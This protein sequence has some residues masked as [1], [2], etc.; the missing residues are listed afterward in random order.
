MT[1]SEKPDL[2]EDAAAQHAALSI[3]QKLDGLP[4]ALAQ[5]AGFMRRHELYVTKFWD[6]YD[7]EKALYDLH[8]FRTGTTHRG[9]Q[10]SL[11]TVWAL[12]DLEPSALSLL[13]VISML[14]P[15]CMQEAILDGE[16]PA[17]E[18]I[19]EYPCLLKEC[20]A[21]LAHLLRSSPIQRDAP[22]RE[23]RI[24][25]L[26]QDVTIVRTKGV[27]GELKSY[28]DLSTILIDV[29]W[30]FLPDDGFILA[31]RV[32]GWNMCAKLCRH[33]DQLTHIHCSLNQP[34]NSAN[35]LAHFRRVTSE[36]SEVRILYLGCGATH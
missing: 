8:S 18:E 32:E 29:Q 30:P 24:C 4:L 26:V 6:I 35:S 33:V 16:L 15:D 1:E 7:D 36:G 31:R 25:P 11:A 5:A 3:A 14:D 27:P 21:A 22:Q 9:Y 20:N 13:N 17:T 34:E 28:F 12:S 2:A 10:H 19:P 23:L